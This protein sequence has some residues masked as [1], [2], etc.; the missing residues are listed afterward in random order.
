MSASSAAIWRKQEPGTIRTFQAAQAVFSNHVPQRNR[1]VVDAKGNTIVATNL[2]GDQAFL[3]AGM[4]EGFDLGTGGGGRPTV[5][6]DR[7]S[8]A[9]S[10]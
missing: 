1:P 9:G 7:S 2:D 8:A 5:F 3:R 10:K 6:T 4:A